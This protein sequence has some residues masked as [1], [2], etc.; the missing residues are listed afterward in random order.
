ML[1]TLSS[2]NEEK[3]SDPGQVGPG[4]NTFSQIGQDE[5]R[6]TAHELRD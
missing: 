6:K 4:Q 3:L 1:M 5:P 2:G